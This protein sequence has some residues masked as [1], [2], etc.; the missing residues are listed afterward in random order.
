MP[1]EYAGMAS[2]WGA[3][4]SVAA[5][6]PSYDGVA[7]KKGLDG[8]VIIACLLH[9]IAMAGLITVIMETGGAN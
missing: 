6:T 8:R 3:N 5:T 4:R 9:D 7:R 1:R 2:C